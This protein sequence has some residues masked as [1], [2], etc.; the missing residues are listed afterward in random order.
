MAPR[1]EGSD[2]ERCWSDLASAGLNKLSSLKTRSPSSEVALRRPG[3]P[4]LRFTMQGSASAS[5]TPEVPLSLRDWN[6]DY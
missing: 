5:L 1:D 2:G 6:A 3:V 4:F